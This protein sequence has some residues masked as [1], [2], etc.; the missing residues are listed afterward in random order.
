M[1][2]PVRELMRSR[3]LSRAKLIAGH[4]GLNKVVESV[5]MMDAPD[6]TDWIREGEFLLTTAYG[7]KDDAAAQQILI[8]RLAERGCSGLGIKT[9]FVPTIPEYMLYQAN[10]WG[11]PLF[12]LP[13]E[14]SLGTIANQLV[15]A[16]M[17]G[18]VTSL[19]EKLTIHERFFR[20]LLTAQGFSGIA[21]TL[22][23]ILR[24]PVMI[25]GAHL[26]VLAE[27]GFGMLENGKRASRG[28]WLD[29]LQRDRRHLSQVNGLSSSEDGFSVYAITWDGV[30]YGYV[31]F[32]GTKRF[33]ETTN[34]LL[35]VLEQAG[36]ATAMEMLRQRA[37]R[38]GQHRHKHELITSLVNPHSISL[39]PI[40]VASHL[41]IPLVGQY[42]VVTIRQHEQ[43]TAA[44]VM[45]GSHPVGMDETIASQWE[46]SLS[47]AGWSAVATF[48]H[49]EW[50]VIVSRENSNDLAFR[51]FRL[52]LTSL[53]S[54]I[55]RAMEDNY[56]CHCKVGV[57]MPVTSLQELHF[58][59]SQSQ[60]MFLENRAWD[61]NIA[62]YRHQYA[63]DLLQ[64][65][66]VQD[67]QEFVN[68][69]I[70]PLLS[71]ASETYLL[72]T[73]ESFL[74]HRGQIS[75]VAEELYLHRNTVIYRLKKI[76]DLLGINVY[77]SKNVLRLSLA[78]VLWRMLENY[79]KDNQ[80]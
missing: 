37:H 58:S 31:I 65:V 73:L 70:G 25:V 8:P 50:I 11:M 42:V 17:S 56:Y 15:S 55:V 71:R 47:E 22:W 41:G 49:P 78:I 69:L 51:H 40:L 4:N 44:P 5:N 14:D 67:R 21:A 10:D 57:G 53:I 13:H 18:S 62:V 74:R 23:A 2:L 7:I 59:Y 80:I 61:N 45:T 75:A 24:V 34:H 52:E 39:S 68:N 72:H 33:L 48:Q 20:T 35:V 54:T 12:E 38:Q 43:Y 1:G 6:I 26:E 3:A 32:T 29:R 46:R 36:I 60:S 79:R 76:N 16:I 30:L 28:E 19:Q 66:S 63:E 27:H 9:R 77:D 64:L